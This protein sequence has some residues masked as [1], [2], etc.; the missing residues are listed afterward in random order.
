MNSPYI[1]RVKIKNFRNFKEINVSLNHKQ[2]IIGENNVGKTNFLRAIQLI[3]DRSYSD[4]DRELTKSD[5]H[6]SI[7]DPMENGEEI[8][9]V[10]EIKNY[11]HNRQLVAQFADAVV[12]IVPPILRFTYK[13]YPK[14]DENK[15][16][17]GYQQ[18]I[19]KGKNEDKLFRSDDRTFLSINVIKALRDVER[20]LKANKNSPL[21]KLVKEYDIADEELDNISKTMQEAA[22]E[23]LDLD[24]IKDVKKI[25]EDKFKTLSGLQH[26]NKINLRPY[27][28]DTERLLYTI[29]VYM[30]L[31]GRSVSELSLGLA[32][33]LY[34]SM[35]M[36][37]L[38]D[39]TIPRILKK[40]VYET[41]VAKDDDTLISSNYTISQRGINYILK[42]GISKEV[43]NNLYKFYD[44]HN[45]EP[46]TVTILAVEEP[47]AHLHPV[48]QRLIYREILKK[49]ESSVIFT[50]H[51]PYIT[52]V[53]PLETIVHASH[54]KGQTKIYSTSKLNWAEKEKEDLERYLDAKKGE[55][56]FGKGV[57]LVEGITEEYIVPQVAELMNTPLDDLGII[58]CNVNSVNFKPYVRLLEALNIPWC[59]VTDGDYY[60]VEIK[61]VEGEKDKITEHFHRM[62]KNGV[63]YKLR[64]INL[65]N[66]MISELGML[67]EDHIPSD[68]ISNQ[69]KLLESKGCFV[70]FYTFEV[71]SMLKGENE[72]YKKVYS[73]VR[74]GGEQQQK[75]F[76]KVLDNG[77]YWKA[78]KKIENNVSKGRF[79]QRLSSHLTLDMTPDYIQKGIKEIIKLVKNNYE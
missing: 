9:I 24:E 7:N 18:K 46:H 36:L 44:Q 4:I 33:I 79:A 41:L 1:S 6:D 43:I 30:G 54:C 5:F 37:L 17:I 61:K 13:F 72:I 67:P 19:F 73:E 50:T 38:K 27:E 28:I 42:E 21:F 15:H 40:D 45:Y 39:K 16:I 64:G 22:D 57:L 65:M 52:A 63:N 8:I 76:D 58:I 74:P 53:A 48:L 25:I 14:K 59:L 70:G 26:D 66:K 29:Q 75:N 10:I 2:V 32:N 11:E 31:N 20:E 56:Y 60:E 68:D 69:S 23:I 55:I 47:E 78:L 71:D 3:L 62:Y 77:E 34:V 49:S 35:M 12:S 51:S